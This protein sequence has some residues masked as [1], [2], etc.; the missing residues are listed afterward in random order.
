MKNRLNPAPLVLAALLAGN[1]GCTYDKQTIHFSDE[2]T[3]A[4]ATDT[5]A[6]SVPVVKKLSKPDEQA[7]EQ[8]V[9]SDLLGRHFW[10]NGDYTAVFVQTTD[11]L[12]A[13]LI[14]QFPH[15]APPIKPIYHA[16]LPTNRTPIDRDTGKSA[17]I[18]MVEVGEP[19]PDD[20]VDAI[21]RWYAGGAVTGFYSY[22]LTKTGAAWQVQNVN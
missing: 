12:E 16:N 14:K 1:F 18:L 21:G 10:D 19:N 2:K 22:H 3:V 15:H 13:N 6:P 11:T 20:S 4:I 17:M 5:V 7:V 9:F 8:V